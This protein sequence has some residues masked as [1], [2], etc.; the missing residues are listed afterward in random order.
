LEEK[1]I[2]GL[3][4][5]SNNYIINPMRKQMYVHDLVTD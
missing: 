2:F 1:N 4:E 5:C 3:S